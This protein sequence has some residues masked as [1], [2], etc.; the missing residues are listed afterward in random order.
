MKIRV[1]KLLTLAVTA[2]IGF[3]STI[4]YGN[5]YEVVAKLP[6]D[7]PPGNIAV[8][9]D[10]RIFLSVHDFFPS[11]L[12]LVEL[13]QDG[14]VTP[15]PNKKWATSPIGENAPGIQSVLGLNTD[16][17]GKLW[18]LDNAGKF[19]TGR[20]L[21]FDLANNTLDRV[22]YLAPPVTRK[23]SF[24]ND[25]AIDTRHNAIYI[26]DTGAGQSSA[27]IVVDL[28]TGMARR[29]LEGSRFT[30]AED[31]DMVIDEKVVTLGGKP[32]RIG[33]NPITIGHQFEWVYFAPMTGLNL[34]RVPT[35]A[36]LNASLSA[37]AL[38]SEVERYG[39]KPIS[40]GIVVDNGG[41]VYITA[42]GDATVGVVKPDGKYQRLFGDK[43][44]A[45]PD[46]FATGPDG[47]IYATINELHR[48]PV[49]NGGENVA[50]GEFKIIRFKPLADVTVGR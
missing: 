31:V 47:Y 49:L 7:I 5:E 25:I 14:S 30:V 42:I 22:I 2:L 3:G 21:A 26:A 23:T 27:L 15:F 17:K 41:N 37:T 36:L 16:G 29:V 12:R 10:G 13:H 39:D 1:Q 19:H 20:L 9:Q 46:G 45:W 35:Q 33:V 50:T 8:S 38:L 32:A 11:D 28:N 24:L 34:Y 40:D 4:S 18:V 43:S 48:S 6:Q 44:L